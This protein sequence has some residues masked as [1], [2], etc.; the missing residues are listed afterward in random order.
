MLGQD[1]AHATEDWR[2]RTGV[3]LQSWRDHP[4]WTPR[5]LLTQLGGYFAPYSTPERTRPHDIDLLL[6]TVG[7]MDLADRKIATL[8]GG[9]RRRLDVA[10]GI[11]GRPELLFL[12]EPTAGFDPQAR[13]EFH[14]LV[15]G[16]ARAEGTTILLTTHDLDEA[17][18]LA[19]RVLVLA[20]GRIVAD[21]T[22]DGLAQRLE[23][24][25]AGAVDGIRGTAQR[26]GGGRDGVR[27]APVRGER[28]RRARPGGAPGEPRGRL[29]RARPAARGR[30]RRGRGPP[31]RGGGPVSTTTPRAQPSRSPAGNPT[32]NAIRLGAHRGWTE[33]SQSIRSTQDQGFYLFTAAITVGYLFLRRDTE[34]EGT[35]LLLPSVALP[36]ILGALIAFG[37]IIGPAYALAMEKEDGTL[38]RHKAVPHG[39]RGYFTGQLLFQSLSL[40]PQMF[41]ILV[42][43]FLLF[44]N[45]M[46]DPSG[47]FTV[48]WV[49]VLGLLATMPIG[50]VIGALVPSTQKVGTWG[51]LPVLVLAGISGIF[52][53]VQM[54][55]GWVQV[56]A[57][58]FPMYWIALGMRSAFLPDEAAAL[59]ID[60]SWRTTQTVLVLGI[61][62]V[63]GSLL[64]PM[65]LRRMAR[66]QTGSQ[67]EAARD[68][69]LQ[70]V[71]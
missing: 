69:S 42:P 60:G 38:L 31:L 65:V 1:P 15:R 10:V 11:V 55:W 43:S 37:V 33:F 35:D 47:W 57:Q 9:Q 23:G 3:V 18:K 17:E 4:R 71:R 27:A 2:A 32:R 66:R 5:R 24:G 50:M 20:A 16:L 14:E 13:R 40:L 46:A 6:E 62:A 63:V 45:L 70:W 22:V 51:M 68:A 26:V 41:V 21:D 61:W 8:S 64:T 39:L 25:V 29:P 49:L 28:R 36:S 19:D 52:Y 12:D 53:P 44:D 7:L 67:V 58:V 48:A 56:V 34:V 54:L 59:E 30:V